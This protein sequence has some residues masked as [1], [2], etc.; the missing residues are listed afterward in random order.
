MLAVPFTAIGA[1][2]QE[3]GGGADGKILVD[4][5]NALTADYQWAIGFSTSGAEELQKKLPRARVVKA[6]NTVF[7]AQMETGRTNGE[8]L[9]T[10]VAG[11]DAAAKEVVLGLARQVGFDA[12]DAGPLRNARMLEPLAFL[13]IQ[14]GNVLKM[15][16]ET[17]FRYVH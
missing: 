13:N 16:K 10:F 2:V 11:D 3:I 5:T 9:T 12:V 6:F 14:L 8:Q 4:A 17:G 7:A 15:G 1:T